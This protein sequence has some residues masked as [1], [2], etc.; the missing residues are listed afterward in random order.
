MY[1]VFWE[2][3]DQTVTTS[4]CEQEGERDGTLDGLPP[5]PTARHLPE[6][7]RDWWLGPGQPI[8]GGFVARG[9]SYFQPSGVRAPSLQETV[10]GPSK[11]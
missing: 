2:Y 10:L 6:P 9:D 7:A 8:I 1:I 5:T 11:S 4:Y 3:L